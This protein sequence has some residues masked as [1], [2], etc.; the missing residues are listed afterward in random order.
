MIDHLNWFKS[1]PSDPLEDLKIDLA[2]TIERALD[3]EEVSRK[4]LAEALG[5]KSPRVS[6]ILS[7]EA[8]LTLETLAS[9]ASALHREV[10]ISLPKRSEP[11]KKIAVQRQVHF[12]NDETHISESLNDSNETLVPWS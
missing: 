11:E 6:K 4:Q 2:V 8:N 1:I 5:V 12:K 9:V 7:G 10:V 3:E